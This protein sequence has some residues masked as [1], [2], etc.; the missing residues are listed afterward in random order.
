MTTTNFIIEFDNLLIF[1]K[2]V[3]ENVIQILFLYN[4]PTKTKNIYFCGIFINYSNVIK[5]L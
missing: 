5:C 1:H 4:I 3:V 2:T